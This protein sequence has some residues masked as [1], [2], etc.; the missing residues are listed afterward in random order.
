MTK[1]IER[2]ELEAYRDGELSFFARRRVERA[3]RGDPA[4]RR[5]LESLEAVGTLL[6]EVDA[7]APAPDLW[8]G[9]RLRLVQE[10]AR[11]EAAPEE[12][13]A[14]WLRAWRR[15]IGMAALGALAAGSVALAL[16][17][18][19]E[20]ASP[21]SVRPSPVGSVRWIDARGNPMMVLR[22]D[23]EATIIWVPGRDS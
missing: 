16:F 14:S 4:L 19:P 5:R 10:D 18:A 22:D 7:A 21:P 12:A 11:R 17:L 8:A 2:A 1:R 15:P 13:A 3:L 6:R 23:R 20:A 9:I